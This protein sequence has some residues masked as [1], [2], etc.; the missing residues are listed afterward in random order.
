[1]KGTITAKAATM[2]SRLAVAVARMPH[3]LTPVKTAV[4]KAHQNQ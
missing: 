1:M 2:S 3:R 4:S